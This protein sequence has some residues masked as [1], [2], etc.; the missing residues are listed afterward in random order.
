MLS[1]SVVFDSERDARRPPET[2]RIATKTE[3]ADLKA[4]EGGR[5]RRAGARGEERGER[6][7]IWGEIWERNREEARGRAR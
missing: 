7:R 1:I 2:T 3:R 6:D 4:S 5:G